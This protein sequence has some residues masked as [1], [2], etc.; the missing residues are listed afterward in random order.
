MLAGVLRDTMPWISEI[1][2][3]A[4]REL[5]NASPKQASKIAQDLRHTLKFV[6]RS[7]FAEMMIDDSKQSHILMMELPHMIER[8]FID[9]IEARHIGEGVK[10]EIESDDGD[11]I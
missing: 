10:G 8:M 9:R 4:H 6:T 1:L 11:L 2:V 5:K 3:E 7:H